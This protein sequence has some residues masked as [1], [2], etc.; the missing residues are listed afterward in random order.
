MDPAT[1]LNIGIKYYNEGKMDEAL[2][3]FDRVVGENPTLA[4]AY[5]YRGL[6]Y[7]A[8]DKAAEAK[9]DFQKLLELDPNHANADEA[10]EFLKS[11]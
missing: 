4:D 9:A 5:Y 3:E 8:Q 10:R 2:A 7:L 6:A 1:L 11:M